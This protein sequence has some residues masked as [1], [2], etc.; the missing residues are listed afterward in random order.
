MEVFK[1]MIHSFHEMTPQID[2]EARAAQSAEIIGDV[3]LS[4]GVS[5]WYGAVLRGDRGP[6]RVG[7]GSNIQDNCVLHT[8]VSVG[9]NVTVGHGAI[10]HGCTVEDGALIGMGAIVMDEVVIGAE[11]LVAAG[12]L[13]T[14]GKQIPPRSLVMGSPAKVVRPLT[15]E[16]IRANA[17]SAPRYRREAEEM[18]SPA[19]KD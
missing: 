14:K 11:S 9:S 16:E 13:V 5:V 6:I 8:A 4:P 17:D 10:L 19:T 1:T 2:P 15:E 18:L 3:T 12:A 7:E